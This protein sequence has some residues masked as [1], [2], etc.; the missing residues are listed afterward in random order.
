[1]P[2][3]AQQE[4]D[5]VWIRQ[6]FHQYSGLHPKLIVHGHTPIDAATH[7]GNRVNLDTGAGYG[8]PLTA[9]VFEDGKVFELTKEGRV[10][11]EPFL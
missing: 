4:E 8:D 6:E 7:Y 9:A 11:L 1:M 5:L 3:D 2:L 10:L